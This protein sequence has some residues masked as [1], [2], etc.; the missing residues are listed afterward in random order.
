MILLDRFDEK[1]DKVAIKQDGTFE[2]IEDE[3]VN[4]S[5]EFDDDDDEK[6]NCS[7]DLLKDNSENDINAANSAKRSKSSHD[8]CIIILDWK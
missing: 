2:K 5:D 6:Y 4:F 8:D 3:M 7:D 1:I